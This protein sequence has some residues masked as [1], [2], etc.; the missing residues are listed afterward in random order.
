MPP[1][2]QNF[3]QGAVA[4]GT[5]QQKKLM[6]QALAQGGTEMAKQTAATQGVMS[7][8]Q[9][10]ALTQAQGN[11]GTVGTDNPGVVQKAQADIAGQGSYYQNLVARQGESQ[12]RL[13]GNVTQAND[14][15]MGQVN[16]AIPLAHEQ[17][18]REL[19][20]LS[21]AASNAEAERAQRSALAQLQADLQRRQIDASDRAASR[22][23]DPNSMDNRYKEALINQINAGIN[24]GP[25]LSEG[26]KDAART[27]A[28]V[29]A[30]NN[31]TAN[32]PGGQASQGAKALRTAIQVGNG[33]PVAAEAALLALTG[34][35]YDINEDGKIK[36]DEK[37]LTPNGNPLSQGYLADLLRQYFAAG[38]AKPPGQ[39]AAGAGI[40]GSLDL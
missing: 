38:M 37:L 19:N 31:L 8:M 4:A 35:G 3:D 9:N 18:Q 25:K 6:L 21:T 12:Q 39:I 13:V 28:Q 2:V 16:A 23:D 27:Q 15:Y 20:S 34:D 22:E 1:A 40:S 24:Q 36:G 11:A 5:E 10:A 30:F 29:S 32:M 26:D 33:N 14:N 17:T 7:D